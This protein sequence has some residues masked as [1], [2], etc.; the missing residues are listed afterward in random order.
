MQGK[1][2]A[3]GGNA[4][5]AIAAA[6]DSQIRCISHLEELGLT[7]IAML[8]DSNLL[9]T[10]LPA[11]SFRKGGPFPPARPL[12]DAGAAIALATDF[13]PHQA[14]TLNMQAVVSLACTHLGMTPAEAVTAATFNAAHTLG[15]SDVTGSLE[16]GKRADVVLLNTADYRDLAYHLGTNLVYMTVRSGNIIYREGKVAEAAAEDAA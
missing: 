7:E 16:P 2:H 5:G 3:S 6:I 11:A 10:L 15:R 14:S 1:L 9:A 13:S 12:I 8:A 4:A